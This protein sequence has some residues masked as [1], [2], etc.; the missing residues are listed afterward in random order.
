MSLQEKLEA[1][2]AKSADHIPAEQRAVMGAATAA[3]RESGILDQ[4]VKPGALLPEFGLPNVREETVA[5]GDLVSRGP[6]VAT[7]YRGVW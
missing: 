5:S 6:L 2:K 7:F 4:V 3:L 1:Q